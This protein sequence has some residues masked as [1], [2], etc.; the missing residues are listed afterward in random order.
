MMERK[1]QSQDEQLRKELCS[2]SEYLK[3]IGDFTRYIYK[4]YIEQSEG[5]SLLLIA[6]DATI[7]GSQQGTS[8]MLLG[9]KVMQVKALASVM[10]DERMAEVFRMARVM[11]ARDGDLREEI[12]HQ[13][14]FRRYFYFVSAVA[15]LW[16]LVVV[17][18]TLVGVFHWAIGITNM[19]LMA[20]VCLSIWRNISEINRHIRNLT[21]EA[22][23]DALERL[24]M[25][26][27]KMFAFMDCAS[28]EV[29]DDD[30]E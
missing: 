29:G 3:T 13:K 10:N 1:I 11:S 9:S 15:A 27:A 24:K 8:H 25:N 22:K 4:E 21:S 19:I 18:L 23:D 2:R 20:G 16:T 14:K 26:M 6:S 28:R 7:G 12:R 17:V 5:R 30:D